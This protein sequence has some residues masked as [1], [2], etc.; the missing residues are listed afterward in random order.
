MDSYLARAYSDLASSF[1]SFLVSIYL[2]PGFSQDRVN[3]HKKLGGETVGPA[4]PNWPKKT[5]ESLIPYDVMLISEWRS[6]PG[7]G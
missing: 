3:F 5:P 6:W 4:D 2:C 7:R 1:I